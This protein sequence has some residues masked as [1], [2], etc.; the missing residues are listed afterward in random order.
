MATAQQQHGLVLQ[1]V[2]A[3]VATGRQGVVGRHCRQKWLVVEW[4][5]GQPGV[6]KRLGQN[7]AVDLASAQHLQQLDG[8]VLLEHQGHLR[9]LFDHLAHK[10]RQQVGTNGVDQAQ[11]Q[12]PGQRVLAALGDFLDVGGLLQHALRLADDFLAQMGDRDLIGTALEK[13]DLQLF[14][15]LL[16]GNRQGGLRHIAG[17]GGFAKMPLTG[18]RHDVFQ[19][20]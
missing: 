8:E 14:F 1:L 13:L 16:D 3:D 5:D 20:S 19:F 7:G 4:G 17:F 2:G 11:R 15:K 9:R 6:G 18:Y 10:I 12:R